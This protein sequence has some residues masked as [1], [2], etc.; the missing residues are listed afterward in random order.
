MYFIGVNRIGFGRMTR[1]KIVWNHIS[2][3]K[4]FELNRYANLT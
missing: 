3:P 2:R 1:G 4:V